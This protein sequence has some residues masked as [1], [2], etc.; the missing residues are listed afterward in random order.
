MAS[1]RRSFTV[2]KPELYCKFHGSQPGG[3][4]GAAAED[5]IAQAVVEGA[6]AGARQVEL[7]GVAPSL[8]ARHLRMHKQIAGRHAWE[9]LLR[10]RIFAQGLRSCSC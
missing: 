8:V 1:R 7:A 3:R 9:N 2:W 10:L 6:N 4:K 5:G